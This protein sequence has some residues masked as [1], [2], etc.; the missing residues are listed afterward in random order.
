MVTV[1]E[2]IRKESTTPELFNAGNSACAGFFSMPAL[3]W[4]LMALVLK[5]VLVA[6]E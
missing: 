5:T 4:A 2:L 3:R 1:K 6:P